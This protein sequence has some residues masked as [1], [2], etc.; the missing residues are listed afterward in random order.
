[1]RVLTIG[2]I[3]LDHV[4]TVDHLVRPGETLAAGGRRAARG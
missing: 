4:L 1:M 3:N 2:S